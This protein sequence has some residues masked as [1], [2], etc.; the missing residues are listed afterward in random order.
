MSGRS[1]WGFAR[2]QEAFGSPAWVRRGLLVVTGALVAFGA[3]SVYSA[4]PEGSVLV[5]QLGRAVVG[6]VVLLA[7]TFFDYHRFQRWSWAIMAIAAALLFLLILPWTQEMAP[8]IN[9]SRRWL[10]LGPVTFQPSELA[11]VAVVIWTASMAV[12]KQDR[13]DSFKYGLLPFLL[14]LGP[15]LMLI[16]LEPHLSATMI[17]AALIGLIL[18]A[19]G[20]RLRH[21]ALV[22]APAVPLL[23]FQIRSNPYQL[24][25]ILAFADRDL[26]PT[27]IGYQLEQAEIAFGSGGLLGV[28]FGESTQKLSYLP[29]AA[30]DFIFPI[31]GEEWGLIGA[32][33]LLGLFLAWTLFG[34]RIA[35]AAPD[36]FGRLLAVGLTGIIAIGAFG[37]MGI[38][39]GMLPT[40]GVSLPFI[41][42][43]GTG[44][45]V[46]LGITGMLLNIASAKRS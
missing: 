35:S 46:A 8:E 29:E 9:G 2:V 7:A 26:D 39:M 33:L 22:I 28:G 41:S 21:F 5:G 45:V 19:A 12:R 43:G 15:V 6:A 38:T 32:L 20:S 34:L 11:K 3:I 14:V 30:N 23:W 13:F 40:T 44:L 1:D 42:S 31:I 4:R 16:L 25:R 17:T 10:F 24:R 37:H 27:G 36:A 18:F